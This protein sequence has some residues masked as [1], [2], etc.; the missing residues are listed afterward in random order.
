[1]AA[2]ELG[3]DMGVARVACGATVSRVPRLP[4]LPH[5]CPSPVPFVRDA[6]IAPERA[7]RGR[8]CAGG[9][10]FHLMGG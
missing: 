5:L 7:G 2:R 10:R 4:V 3:L 1:M 9:A 6:K 8:P